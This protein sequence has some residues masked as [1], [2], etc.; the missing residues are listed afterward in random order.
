VDVPLAAAFWRG[1][2]QQAEH[3]H[4]DFD[5]ILNSYSTFFKYVYF[6]RQAVANPMQYLGIPA[7]GGA[8]TPC[9]VD[10]KCI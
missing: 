7:A 1:L 5:L 9:L 4:F 6:T 3:C 2:R 8:S 10:A